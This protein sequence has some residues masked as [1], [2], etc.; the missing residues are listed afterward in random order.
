MTIKS[1]ALDFPDSLSMH[2]RKKNKPIQPRKGE[3][4]CSVKRMDTQDKFKIM[5]NL[6]NQKLRALQE[7][8]DL[9]NGDSTSSI[10][11]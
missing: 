1:S 8:T 9:R 3:I 6:N 5:I 4:R 11:D 2:S 10:S 7:K